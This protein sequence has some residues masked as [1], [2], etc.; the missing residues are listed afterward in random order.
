MVGTGA[1]ALAGVQHL[2]GATAA[3][4]DELKKV[5]LT[6]RPYEFNQLQPIRWHQVDTV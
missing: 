5:S 1:G 3:E 4:S 6:S 2:G